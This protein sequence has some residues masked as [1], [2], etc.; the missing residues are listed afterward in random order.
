ML[1]DLSS[2]RQGYAIFSSFLYSSSKRGQR[3]FFLLGYFPVY[4]TLYRALE[5][6]R[7]SW[8]LYPQGTESLFRL[9]NG[10]ERNSARH[11]GR[12]PELMPEPP[13]GKER[14]PSACISFPLPH[15]KL[16]GVKRGNERPARGPTHLLQSA[17]LVLLRA[18][19]FPQ[20]A[21]RL[22]KSHITVKSASSPR[23][24]ES[25][26]FLAPRT[27]PEKKMKKSAKALDISLPLCYNT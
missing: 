27:H 15:L 12:C 5:A 14:K 26:A 22:G 16:A 24:G 3:A 23:N 25:F 9:L 13:S 21:P 20:W 10:Y 2:P 19:F 1:P 7:S 11:T 4:A 17:Q 18:H 8:P 6:V